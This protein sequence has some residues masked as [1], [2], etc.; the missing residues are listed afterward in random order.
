MRRLPAI[1]RQARRSSQQAS[2]FALC[3]AL[4]LA[5]LTAFSGFSRSVSQSMQQEARSL[6]AADI[7]IRSYDPIP[8]PLAQAVDRLAGQGRVEGAAI[9][10]FYSVVRAPDE[11]ASVL[12]SLKIVEAPGPMWTTWEFFRSTRWKDP[13]K[14]GFW[15]IPCGR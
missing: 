8:A 3:V 14:V 1:L 5:T 12:A 6:H 2:L 10:E 7:V 15:L 13:R 9:H 11:K 4:S